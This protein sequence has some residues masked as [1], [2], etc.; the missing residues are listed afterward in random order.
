V[1]VTDPVASSIIA[2]LNQPGGN[3]TG[4]AKALSVN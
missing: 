1:G 4:F 3:I 2:R